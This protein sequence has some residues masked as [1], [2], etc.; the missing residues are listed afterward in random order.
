[1]AGV[2]ELGDVFPLG[3][4]VGIFVAAQLT[5]GGA[6]KNRARKQLDDIFTQTRAH[7]LLRYANRWLIL[8]RQAGAAVITLKHFGQ[9]AAVDGETHPSQSRMINTLG[10][11]IALFMYR[12]FEKF[13]ID[14]VVAQKVIT[15]DA[16]VLARQF[17]DV[18]RNLVIV[19]AELLRFE[20][21]QTFKRHVMLDF[22]ITGHV[23]GSFLIAIGL[24]DSWQIR[25]SRDSDQVNRWCKSWRGLD[26]YFYKN[27]TVRQVT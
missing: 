27:S 14:A 5:K 4:I 25:V 13:E 1:M 15:D 17:F 16:R 6:A 18:L 22:R 11:L 10:R 19:P 21:R 24:L 20:P 8:R 23:K 2:L 12:D 9:Q 7:A 26:H 3:F